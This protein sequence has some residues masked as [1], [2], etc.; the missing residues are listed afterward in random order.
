MSAVQNCCEMIILFEMAHASSG[1]KARGKELP[2]DEQVWRR[3]L[4]CSAV[5]QSDP[6]TLRSTYNRGTRGGINNQVLDPRV[7]IS[8]ATRSW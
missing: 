2:E 6:P 5:H 8:G 7:R 4:S 3:L 1:N